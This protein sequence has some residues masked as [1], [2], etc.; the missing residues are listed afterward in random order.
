MD[1][2]RKAIDRG[3]HDCGAAQYQIS[4]LAE[5]MEALSAEGAWSAED[6]GHIRVAIAAVLGIPRS[7]PLGSYTHSLN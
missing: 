6:L 7:R 4:A 2:K 5:Y 1:A 3:I